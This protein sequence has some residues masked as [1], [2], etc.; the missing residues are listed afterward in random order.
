MKEGYKD[1]LIGMIP[2]EWGVVKQGDVATFHNG[3]AYS[4][5]EWEDYGTP[6]IRLQNLTGRGEEYYYSNLVLPEHQ[7]C[8]KGDLLYMWSASFGA[9]FWQGE[10]AIFHYHI[11]KIDSDDKALNKKFH[12]YLLDDITLRMK[13]QSHGST[14]MH[15]TKG[16]MEKLLIQL[17]SLP[18]QSKIASILSTVD[19]K[20]DSINERIKETRK[21]K[22]GLMQQLLTRGI[23]HT[24]FK[25]SPL[26]EIPEN[27]KVVKIGSIAQTFAG[28]TPNRSI[29]D[30]YSGTIPWIKSGEV[31]NRNI[32]SSE[33]CITEKAIKETA[34]KLIEPESVLVALYGATAGNV[35]ILKIRA[36]SNQ[37]VLAVDSAS[38][39][40]TNGFIYYFLNQVTKKLINLTQGSGQP[41]LSKGIVDSVLIPIPLIDE[42]VNIVGCLSTFDDK[43]DVLL[44]N[45]STYEQLK[46]GLMQQLLIGKLRVKVI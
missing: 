17:P 4:L 19:D 25:D 37:A 14:M 10:K 35:G 2:E 42:Q 31:R 16:D 45:K 18:E 29:N 23:G 1:T 38:D 46:K 20:I 43:L 30:Y 33:E 28:G 12:Y 3:R 9:Y 39:K 32:S 27:W 22:Q 41:N 11:W 21:L 5:S 24:R 44:E 34:T 40:V 26:G 13:N 36:C 8:H 15:V 7:Y 6:V